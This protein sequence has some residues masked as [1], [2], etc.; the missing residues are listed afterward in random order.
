[1]DTAVIPIQRQLCE[2]ITQV[3]INFGAALTERQKGHPESEE[4]GAV[5]ASVGRQ[6]SRDYYR[7]NLRVESAR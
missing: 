7:I 6:L 1:M 5:A 3:Q 2:Y 4:V